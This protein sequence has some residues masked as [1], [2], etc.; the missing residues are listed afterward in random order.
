MSVLKEP[1]ES[2]ILLYS[3]G[4]NLNISNYSFLP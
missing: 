3:N 2:N 4:L 1:T